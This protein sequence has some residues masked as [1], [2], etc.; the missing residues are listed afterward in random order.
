MANKHGAVRA[1]HR[2]VVLVLAGARRVVC[3]RIPRVPAT[4]KSAPGH[5]GAA[6]SQTGLQRVHSESAFILDEAGNRWQ[7]F[8]G[9]ATGWMCQT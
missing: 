4:A 1:T 6:G 7:E 9:K 2:D 8:S 5:S 3:R